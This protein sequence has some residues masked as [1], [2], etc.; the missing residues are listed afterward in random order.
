AWKSFKK[1]AHQHNPPSEF[2]RPAGIVNEKIDT[3][4]GTHHYYADLETMDEVFLA[5]TEPTE[6]G[7]E[8]KPAPHAADAGATPPLP[9]EP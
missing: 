7:A 3:L 9:T 4:T 2:P 5:G 6:V 1:A 8:V